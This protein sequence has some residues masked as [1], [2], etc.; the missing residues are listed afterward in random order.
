MAYDIVT[1]KNQFVCAKCSTY[2][3]PVIGLSGIHGRVIF[4]SAAPVKAVSATLAINVIV[5]AMRS[6]NWGKVV[7]LS[8]NLGA[9]SPVRRATQNLAISVATCT[10]LSNGYISG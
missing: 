1:W 5:L 2:N 10:Y 3:S 4:R 7:S 6:F 9:S 8:A